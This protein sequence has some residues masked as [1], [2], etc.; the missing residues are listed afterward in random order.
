MGYDGM[1]FDMLRYVREEPDPFPTSP[2]EKDYQSL[3]PTFTP[4][5][6]MFLEI[7]C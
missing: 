5:E 4:A 7:F 1:Q 6:G 3:D 2:K